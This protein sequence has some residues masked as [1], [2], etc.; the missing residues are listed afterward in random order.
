MPELR[1]ITISRKALSPD[2]PE[3]VFVERDG[4]AERTPVSIGVSVGDRVEVKKGL[5]AGDHV[6]VTGLWQIKDG[7][8]V[9]VESGGA[10][11]RR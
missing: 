7:A 5:A 2:D 8:P 1:A 11:D 9:R 6:I 4:K 3:A 10:V